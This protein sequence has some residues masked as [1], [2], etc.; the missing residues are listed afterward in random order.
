MCKYK[1]F[2]QTIFT[3][4]KA[5]NWLNSQPLSQLKSVIPVLEPKATESILLQHITSA[6]TVNKC[7]MTSV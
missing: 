5:W 4:K 1:D 2:I 6:E 7:G 3:V